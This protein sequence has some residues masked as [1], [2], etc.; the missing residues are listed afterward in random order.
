[1]KSDSP[2]I[3]ALD[4]TDLERVHQLIETTAPFIGVYKFGLEF[5]LRHGVS[6]VRE[7]Q[8]KWNID[9]FL[10]LK[11]HDIPNTVAKSAAT[12]IDLEPFILTVHAAGGRSMVEAAANALPQT[13]IAG[14]TVLT[15]L[16]QPEIDQLGLGVSIDS[17]ALSLAR[18][19]FEGGARA[20]VA[21]PH[22]VASLR[23][24]FPSITLITPGIRPSLE[25]HDDQRRT[26]TP[27]DALAL[28]SDYLVIGRPITED[29]SP[30]E[31][32]KR[33]LVSLD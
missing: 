32:A 30:A 27:R 28:G 9:V 19:A 31:A 33:I 23:K 24:S 18:R 2:I 13:M 5:Y 1:M 4:T 6:V 25:D 29:P 14:V 8:S 26:M 7:I 3:L 11:L 16:D 22:E 17:L 10:D 21:S 15:S 20:I 12:L